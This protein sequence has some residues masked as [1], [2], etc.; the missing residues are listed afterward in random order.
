MRKPYSCAVRIWLNQFLLS[1][2]NISIPLH[3]NKAAS[4]NQTFPGSPIRVRPY[5]IF[6]KKS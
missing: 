3:K 2:I 5:N 1:D 4:G 6:D